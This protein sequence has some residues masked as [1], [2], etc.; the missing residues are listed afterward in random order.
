[1]EPPEVSQVLD[2]V[3]RLLTSLIA[4]VVG[5]LVAYRWRRGDEK[6]DGHLTELRADVF[7]PML[8]YL[9]KYV[10]PILRHDVGNVDVCIQQVPSTGGLMVRPDFEHMICVRMLTEPLQVYTF[11][12]GAVPALPLPPDGPLVDDARRHHFA[13][14]FRKWDPLI[15][16][17]QEYNDECQRYVETLQARIA[18]ENGLLP[19]FTRQSQALGPEWVNAAALAVIVF[20]R[21]IGRPLR[22]PTFKRD[23]AVHLLSYNT[24]TMAQAKPMEMVKL[25][26]SVNKLIADRSHVQKLLAKANPL[27]TEAAAL[28][29]TIDEQRLKRTLPGKCAYL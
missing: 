3:V 19:E 29:V 5:A 16:R 12:M 26:A 10:L 25:E 4:G 9:D 21:Q 13:D 28:R 24:L 7:G 1:M 23:G 20:L 15:V 22:E 27:A 6:Q 11:G 14:L 8:E 18:D 17:F 2:W